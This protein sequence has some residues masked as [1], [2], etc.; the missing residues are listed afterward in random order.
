MHKKTSRALTQDVFF[1]LT[2]GRSS[3]VLPPRLS[4]TRWEMER[5][6]RP[7]DAWRSASSTRDS[8]SASRSAVIFRSV[9][10]ISASV[11]KRL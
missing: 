4:Y 1:C 9:I 3:T 8:V 6:V 2:A 5:A 11:G 7:R 10:S